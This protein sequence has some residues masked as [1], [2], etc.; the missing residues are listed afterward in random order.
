MAVDRQ[1]LLARF[2][3]MIAR[4]EPI[5]G[6]GA[7]TGLSAK[8]EEA[9]GI[10]LIVIY[11][12]G[13]YRMAGRGSLA[14]VLAYGNA[15]E[16]VVDM[17]REVLPVVRHTPVLAG[18]NGTDP[19]C[20]FDSFLDHLKAI[21]FAGV[22]NFPTVGLI[23]GVFRA[24]LEETG[25]SYDLEVDLI[26][27]AHAKNMLTTPYVF[28][29]DDARA[30]TEAGADIIVAHMGLTTGGAIG[31]ETALTLDDCIL[32]IAT[33]ASAGRAIRSDV[34]VLCH[35][36]PISTP[37]DARYVLDRCPSCHGFYGASSME[38]L[39]SEIALTEQTRSFKTIRRRAATGPR[40]PRTN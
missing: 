18:V 2:Q 32:R 12:S 37:E 4:G 33:I 5:I 28:N 34:I 31:A 9:G 21:G 19:F 22:Q 23:D 36:G 20:H 24:N 10:D 1:D 27:L 26:R 38:R 40:D 13:R 35:G 14:G 6:G 39:P 16:I 25:M 11:N 30:M 7:G 8:C 3:A 17:A 15:N 29:E